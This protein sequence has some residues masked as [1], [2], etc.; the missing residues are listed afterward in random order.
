MNFIWLVILNTVHAGHRWLNCSSKPVTEYNLL[1]MTSTL[2]GQCHNIF[3]HFFG[4]KDSTWSA[5]M[6]RPNGFANFF[7]FTKIFAKN[8][9][10][11]IQRLRRHV[12]LTTLTRNFWTL[13]SDIFER[14]K[15]R[16][17]ISPVHMGPRSNPLSPKNGRRSHE[18]VPKQNL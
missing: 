4:L 10:P 1:W 12:L 3:N 17:T 11:R 7:V 8:V 5:H 14:K 16:E 2:K 6:N 13:R 18:T 15:V 9:W